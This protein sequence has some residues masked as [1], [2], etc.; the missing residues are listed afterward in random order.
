MRTV[1]CSLAVALCVALAVPVAAAKPTTTTKSTAAKPTVGLT[2]E[3]EAR[4]RQA[5]ALLIAALTTP[6]VLKPHLAD[7]RSFSALGRSLGVSPRD[8]PLFV[9]TALEELAAPKA[10]ATSA[11]TFSPDRCFW[12]VSART[13]DKAGVKRESM[14]F[15][16]GTDRVSTMEWVQVEPD[17]RMLFMGAVHVVKPFPDELDV[18]L[19]GVRSSDI[20]MYEKT[21]GVWQAATATPIASM[22][23]DEALKATA[24]QVGLAEARYRLKHHTYTA[25]LDATGVVLTNGITAKITS[26]GDMAFLAALQLEGGIVT[27]DHR[28]GLT[29]VSSCAP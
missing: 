9:D 23:C 26:A 16:E 7:R 15:V 14:T 1:V 21:D 3:G 27:I 6:A 28:R 8:L 18:L 19:D 25:D 5:E 24:R 10:P 12:S 17:P 29:V 13:A 4:I 2:G 20:T 22:P 11:V